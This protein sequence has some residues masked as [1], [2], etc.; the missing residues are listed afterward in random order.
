MRLLKKKRKIKN[1]FLQHT[2]FKTAL[3]IANA[4]NSS[5]FV[6]KIA[7]YATFHNTDKQNVLLVV[8]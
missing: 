7:V 5:R 1:H 4:A 2:C 6:D 3:N 8:F